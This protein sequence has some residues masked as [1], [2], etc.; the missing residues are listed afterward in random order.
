[1]EKTYK[2]KQKANIIK[3]LQDNKDKHNTVENIL[4]YF[5]SINEPIG[6]ATVYR[7]LDNLVEENKVRKYISSESG[8]AACYQYIDNE[9]SC[10]EH[11]H[12]KCIK[13]GCLI[14]L[15]CKELGALSKHIFKEHEFTLDLCRTTLYGTCKKCLKNESNM[16]SV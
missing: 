10:I 1:M 2:T 4:L 16:E 12:M 6:K 14:H 9:N 13:C 7:H 8:G 5:K 3:Y 15:N 11:Y